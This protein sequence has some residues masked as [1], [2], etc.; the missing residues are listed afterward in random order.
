VSY[1]DQHLE[2]LSSHFNVPKPSYYTECYKSCPYPCDNLIG[3]FRHND[4]ILNWKP[5]NPPVGHIYHE[6]GHYLYHYLNRAT[7]FGNQKINEFSCEM[8]ARKLEE[9]A[10]KYYQY[11]QLDIGLALGLG[12]I[13]LLIGSMIALAYLTQKS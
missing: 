3:C 4:V 7:P 13:L 1:I 5:S 12:T 2:F 10:L 6:F 11:P 9:Y 8:Y